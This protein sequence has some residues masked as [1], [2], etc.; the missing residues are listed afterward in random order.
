MG[1]KPK[2]AKAPPLP[3]PQ[4]TPE[5]APETEDTAAKKAR[6]TSGY[7]KTILTG[8]LAPPRGELG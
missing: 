8:N 3:A 5:V 2:V 6:K 4:A 7:G 1:S